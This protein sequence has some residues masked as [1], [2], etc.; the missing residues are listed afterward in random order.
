[1]GVCYRVGGE[2]ESDDEEELID[3]EDRQLIDL[4]LQQTLTDAAPQGTST[5]ATLRQTLIEASLQGTWTD[6]APQGTSTNSALRHD[7]APIM[8]ID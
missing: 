6:A 3:N 7:A 5:D 2:Y 4:V 8:N 1:M